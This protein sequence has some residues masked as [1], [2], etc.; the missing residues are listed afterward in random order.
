MP[1][2][3]FF[4]CLYTKPGKKTPICIFF[5]HTPH[6]KQLLLHCSS[7]HQGSALNF[8]THIFIKTAAAYYRLQQAALLK[9]GK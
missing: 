6:H 8:P 3:T 1:R 4:Y 2:H 9:I 5:Q 7:R